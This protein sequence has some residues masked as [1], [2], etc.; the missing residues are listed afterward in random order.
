LVDVIWVLNVLPQLEQCLCEK[1]NITPS[2]HVN[3]GHS[4][5]T[6]DAII[7]AVEQEPWRS[8]Q[9]M[10]QELG[11]SQLRVLEELDDEL[12]PFQYLW[13]MNLFPDDCPLQMKFYKWLHQHYR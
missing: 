1:G 10:A 9:H 4:Q 2:A 6:N 13:S 11:L 8:S 5:T 12:H 3:A 7:A